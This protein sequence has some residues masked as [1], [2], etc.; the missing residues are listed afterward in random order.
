MARLFNSSKFSMIFFR[1]FAISGIGFLWRFIITKSNS[2]PF[3]SNTGSPIFLFVSPYT[4]ISRCIVNERFFLV[5]IILCISGFSKIIESIITSIQIS[6]VNFLF[7]PFSSYSKPCQ[8]MSAITNSPN[9]DMDIP[10][11]KTARYFS[12]LSGIPSIRLSFSWFP[13]KFSSFRIILK[14]FPQVFLRE[15]FDAHSFFRYIGLSHDKSLLLLVRGYSV[16]KTLASP[17]SFYNGFM[18]NKQ[19]AIA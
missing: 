10:I 11:H 9:S 14:K 1:C 3:N 12:R 19:E 17:V 15:R 18:Y 16:L 5:S 8:M 6:V 13:S 2:F 4:F 7:W